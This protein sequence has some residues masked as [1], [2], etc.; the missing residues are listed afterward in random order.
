[1]AN[2]P[3]EMLDVAGRLFAAVTAGDVGAVR[4]LYAPNAVIWHNN[5]GREQTPEQNLRVLA[6]IAAN[7]TNFRYEDGRC[8]PTAT[9]FVEQHVTRGTGPS[10]AEFEIPAC[11]VCTVVD[12]KITRLDE[13]LDSAQAARI[14]G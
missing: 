2:D 3:D 6:W 1:M 7:V 14:A 10:G 13:Y 12:G 11:I 8:Q 4:A 5:D 9:G